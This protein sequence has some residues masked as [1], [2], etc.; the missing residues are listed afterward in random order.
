MLAFSSLE[1]TFSLF[2]ERR[3]GGSAGTAAYWFAGLGLASAI[4]QGGLIRRLV[5][6]FGEPRLIPVGFLLLTAGMAILAVVGS[7]M[8]LAI[9]LLLVGFGQGLAA[10]TVSGLLSRSVTPAR[11]GMIFGALLSAQTLARLINYQ[12]ANELL[13]RFGPSAPFWEGAAVAGVGLLLSG[14][15][16]RA[17]RPSRGPPLSD[18]ESESAPDPVL[19][20]VTP[21]QDNHTS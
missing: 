12:G 20:G 9:A 4:M 1:G 5:P 8:G 10:P 13:A 3:M 18:S 11:Q 14:W 6:R 7:S 16:I 2:L 19:A 17:S 15:A 21:D